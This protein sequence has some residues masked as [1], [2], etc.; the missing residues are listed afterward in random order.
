MDDTLVGRERK[1]RELAEGMFFHMDRKGDRYTLWP[2]AGLPEPVRREHLTLDEVEKE[3]D[4]WKL[5]GPG[6]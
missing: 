3:L 4:L 1:A 6:Q 5:R 2:V